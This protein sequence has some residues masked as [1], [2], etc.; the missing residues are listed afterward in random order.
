[1]LIHTYDSKQSLAYQA[2][3]LI[4]SVDLKV[5]AVSTVDVC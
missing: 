3:K 4:P 1:M 2:S 5:H